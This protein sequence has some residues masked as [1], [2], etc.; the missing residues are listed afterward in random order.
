MWHHL[1]PNTLRKLSNPAL[2]GQLPEAFQGRWL[3]HHKLS[4]IL[5]THNSGLGA[6]QVSQPQALK[7]AHHHKRSGRRSQAAVNR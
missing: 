1:S 2:A 6:A 7:A 5:S 4:V 3:T